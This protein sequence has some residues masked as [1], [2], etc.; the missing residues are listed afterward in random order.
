MNCPTLV[1]LPVINGVPI[2]IETLYTNKL[3]M[4]ENGLKIELF[5]M[6]WDSWGWMGIKMGFLNRIGGMDK[7]WVC[8]VK[9][10][11]GVICPI[12][13]IVLIEGRMAQER[14]GIVSGLVG[15]RRVGWGE[16]VINGLRR[17]ISSLWGRAGH[18]RILE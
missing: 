10:G 18:L 1:D 3:G 12:P 9:P 5:D 6:S 13:M 15:K 16:N 2:E 7:K 17:R 11:L 14:I 4:R 8:G